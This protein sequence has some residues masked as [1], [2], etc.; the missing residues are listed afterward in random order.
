M[1]RKTLITLSAIVLIIVLF[2]PLFNLVFKP[3]ITG[4]AVNTKNNKADENQSFKIATFAS[5]EKE[6]GYTYCRDKLYASC[7]GQL[8]EVNSSE[9]KC[10]GKTHY[11]NS[12]TLGETYKLADENVSI[13]SQDDLTAWAVSG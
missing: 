7:N 12:I 2:L 4:F 5:C 6:E 8:I 13:K 11:I 9:I 10:N 1:Q 3:T